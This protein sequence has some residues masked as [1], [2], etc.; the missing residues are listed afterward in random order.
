MRNTRTFEIVKGVLETHPCTR[1]DDFALIRETAKKFGLNTWGYS[2][3]FALTQ[4]RDKHLPPFETI[5]RARRKL[6][7]EY[8]HLRGTTKVQQRRA[9]SYQRYREF[10][11]ESEGGL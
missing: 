5:T 6:Q 8:P 2:F 4:W 9:E 7:E 11:R 10:F 3:D 1:S